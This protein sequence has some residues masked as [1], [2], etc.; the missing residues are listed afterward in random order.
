ME[1]FQ[2][3]LN[4]VWVLIATVLIFFMQAGFGA[5]EAGFTR[6]KNS[7]NVAMKNVTD[8][9]FA[10]IVFALIGFPLMFG[11][12][13]GG[14]FGSTNFFLNMD[15]D[16]WNWSFLLF[17]IAFSS[18]AATIVSGAIA[19]RSKFS[20]YIIGTILIT[21]I[22]YPIY[23][24]WAWGS[25]WGGDSTGW[26]E[27]L[28]FMD[29]AGS[30]VVHSIG[31]WVAFAACIA[32]GPRIGKYNEDKTS[33]DFSPSSAVIATLGMF[34]LWF[35]WFGF[36]AGSTTVGDAS[37]ALIALNTHI[38]AVAGGFAAIL[39]SWFI[40]GLPNVSSTLNGVLGGLVAITAGCNV[41]GPG[42]AFLIGLIGGIVTTL[43]IELVEKKFRVDDAVGAVAVH[44]FAGAWGTVATAIFAKS[45]MLIAS[46]RMTQIGVQVIGVLAGFI[47]AFGLG[48]IFYMVLKKMNLLRVST[49]DEIAG[50]NV[51]E[52]GAK[53][54]MLDTLI[55]MK[56]IAAAKGDL[57]KRLKIEHGEDTA[58]LN[59][60]F[61]QVL[62][63]LNTIV[64]N[65]KKQTT[66]VN[67]LSEDMYE[68][69]NELKVNSED[70][71]NFVH[72]LQA[73]F[74][75]L[76]Q[77]FE[78][79]LKTD[80]QVVSMIQDSFTT[81]EEISS[82]ITGLRNHVS[83]LTKDVNV[84]NEK[85]QSVNTKI[86]K[87]E[88]NVTHIRDF[89][90]QIQGI[91]DT[92]ANISKKINLLSLNAAIEAAR[93][94]DSGSGFAVV[95]GEIRAL[96]N[97]TEVATKQIASIIDNSVKKM[98]EVDVDI[99]QFMDDFRELNEELGQIPAKFQLMDSDMEEINDYTKNFVNHVDRISKDSHEINQSKK[100]QAIKLSSFTDKIDSISKKSQTGVGIS[101]RISDISNTMKRSSNQLDKEV[102]QFKTEH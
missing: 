75:E 46:D 59:E 36:N 52:H 89:S 42:S 62:G 53:I 72:K 86:E 55:S 11:E 8:F 88:S 19:E 51:S 61:N 100:E 12:S 14:F 28:G 17:Q 21:L 44:G 22:I 4:F 81:M 77:R 25:L 83:L 76:D 99:V 23:G 49:E 67:D 31:A 56:E 73:Y 82:Q 9:I 71:H 64:S 63:R 6:A 18:T 97:D 94:G 92:I 58:E 95:A 41:V 16:P 32:V 60:A 10:S 96:S 35:G 3:N 102:G 1:T 27:N 15:D 38:S 2:L 5:L 26:L 30:T 101:K 70:Q 68:L 47:W 57:T 98:E 66:N 69:S 33:N 29:F 7:I 34:L 48:I 74:I 50:L 87:V 78:A 39:V 90:N 93:A 45:D 43:A 65:I 24:H 37:I 54:S 40:K 79:D 20:G 91:I 80:E 13:V 84:V 85:N